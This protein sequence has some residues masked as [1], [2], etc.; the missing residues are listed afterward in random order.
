MEK[1]I[2][3]N[4]GGRVIAIEDAAYISLKAYFESLRNY[5]SEEESREEIIND[6]ES[7]VAELMEA[8][9]RR[10]NSA[11][12]EADVQEIIS[13]M[14]R[15]EDFA[16]EDEEPKPRSS[17]G[18]TIQAKSTKR[19]FR[20]SN[21]KILGGVCSG[22]AAYLNVD[23]ALV[24]IVFA[25]LTF[26]GWGFGV[27]L[28]IL[29][30]IFVP[31][32]PLES[33]RGRRLFRN[34]DDKWLGGV[35]SGIATYFGIQVWVMRLLFISPIIIS[36]FSGSGWWFF[37]FGSFFF[38]SLTGTF[39]L[40]YIVLWVVLPAARSQF[41]K[42]EMRGEKVDLNSIRQNIASNT[43]ELRGRVREWGGE[44]GDS[45][46]NFMNSRGKAFGREVSDAA[47]N[48]TSRGGNVIG[49][50]FR[51]LF[52]IIGIGIAFLLFFLLIGYTFGGFSQLAND[53]VLQTVRMRVL[54]WCSVLLLIGI[55][56]IA[57]VVTLVRRALNLRRRHRALSILFL[58]LWFAGIGCAFILADGLLK[59]F[60]TEGSVSTE[61]PVLQPRSR[62]LTLTVP[63]DMLRYSNALPWLR[64]D[65][66]GWDLRGD[67]MLSASV[68]IRAS[69]SPD[70]LYHVYVVRNSRG[71]NM[72]D[73]KTRAVNISYTVQNLSGS[74]S[75][76]AFDSYFPINKQQGFRGQQVFVNVQVPAGAKIR[77]DGSLEEK[78]NDA[79]HYYEGSQHSISYRNW[80]IRMDEA[81]E[82]TDWKD[83]LDYIMSADGRL[84]NSENIKD[85]LAIETHTRYRQ[86]GPGYWRSEYR[87]SIQKAAGQSDSI[88]QLIEKLEARKESLEQD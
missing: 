74:D 55:P 75:I 44:V 40:I 81:F 65:I 10:G 36:V 59:E 86:Y 54:G 53:Y 4:L 28:Y 43:E 35:A 63:G 13:G 71:Q 16:A 70:S 39:M 34:T 47:R 8:R 50:I 26:G 1:I 49:S 14:G 78:L 56:L 6:I 62:S 9:L 20:D 77:F 83:D 48:M 38:G 80:R 2:N 5:F 37:G 57:L 22:L 79:Q 7:R 52:S 64:G 19:F 51:V 46:K 85:T 23:P 18:N 41:E 60:N 76:L 32:Q 11:I 31:A 33:Y 84:V 87:N 24:R 58:L 25:I 61:V 30:W 21:D 27:M 15:V 67:S 17:T 82:T 69:L 88:D 66:E 12:T 73:A 45:A 68:G 42:M 72:T 29:L 3:I